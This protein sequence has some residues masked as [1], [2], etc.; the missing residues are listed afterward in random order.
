MTGRVHE[1]GRGESK[2][3]NLDIPLAPGSG[4]AFLAAICQGFDAAAAH[5]AGALVM[6]LGYDTHA[7]DPL[8]LVRVTTGAFREAGRVV[9]SARIPVI[10]QEGGYQASV[11]GDPLKRFLQGL[12][13]GLSGCLSPARRPRPRSR[14]ATWR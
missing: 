11:I 13:S 6:A 5:G 8:S 7:E 9:T 1:R 3:F 10:V 4:E 2:G 14:P 12:R